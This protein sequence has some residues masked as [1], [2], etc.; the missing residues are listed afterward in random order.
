MNHTKPVHNQMNGVFVHVANLK[1]SVQWYAE[2][3][4]LKI[5]LET[6]RSPVYNIPVAGTTSLTLDD[7]SFDPHFVHNP[8]TNPIFNFYAPD[9]EAA[10]TFIHGLGI[11]IVRD[12]EWAGETAWFH[13]KDPDG[14]VMMIC[15]C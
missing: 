2:L 7:H 11:E 4:G 1:K 12:L 15:N 10:L 3:L 8:G 9:I 14:N 5:D 13:I 6:V